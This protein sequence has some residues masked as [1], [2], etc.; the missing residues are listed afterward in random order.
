MT[1]N[2]PLAVLDHVNIN[3][4]DQMDA[5]A[6]LYA[7]LGFQLTPR[8]FHS[9]G[10]VNHLAVFGTNYLEL[11]GFPRGSTKR[12][13]LI[14]APV[15]LNAFVFQTEDEAQAYH[16]L[17]DAGV[18]VD[19]PIDI[20]R[21]VDFQ[22]AKRDATFR[23]FRLKSGTFPA[24]RIIFCHHLTRDLIWRDEWRH[25]PNGAID[26]ARA[27]VVA[28][29]PAPLGGL[30]ARMFGAMAVRRTANGGHSLVVGASRLEIKR[31][32][33]FRKEFGDAGPDPLERDQ[34]IAAVT[35]RTWSL[36]QAA[37]ALKANGISDVRYDSARIIV[38]AHQTMQVALEFIE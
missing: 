4:R 18:P 26:I 7:R 15:G 30:F 16:A 20:S 36:E 37:N 24:G 10:S 5:A 35:F 6:E 14:D 9:L 23:I 29:D 12:Q 33:E 38:P 21:P 34:Y 19:A 1:L 22:G 2:L 27:I 28:S 3:V 8:G 13:D 31:P 11:V 17:V 25:H 32:E